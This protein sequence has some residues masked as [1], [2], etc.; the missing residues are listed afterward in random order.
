MRRSLILR[1]G[2]VALSF[3]LFTLILNRPQ[4]ILTPHLGS[5]FWYPTAGLGLALMLAVS[6]WYGILMWACCNL[7][8]PSVFHEPLS[9]LSVML[10]E[11]G[12]VLCYTTAAYVLRNVVKIDP[13]LR[14]RRDVMLYV[15]V[16]LTAAVVSTMI[17]VGRLTLD[18]T[19]SPSSFPVAAFNWFLSDAVGLLGICPFLLVIVLPKIRR[20]V[21]PAVSSDQSALFQPAF[22]HSLADLFEGSVQLATTMF[23]LWLMFAHVWNFLPR[24]YL[25]FL[26]LTWM[27]LRKGMRRVSMGT[28][29]LNVGV[30]VCLHLFHPTAEVLEK[31]AFFLVICSGTGLMIASEVSEREY[32]A[33]DLRTKTDF[34]NALIENCPLG[35]VV[36]NRDARVEMANAAFEKM[37][38]YGRREIEAKEIDP[39]LA[40]DDSHPSS[41]VVSKVFAGQTVSRSGQRRRKDGIILDVETY[42][43]PLTVN[44]TVQGAYK[45]FQDISSRVLAAETERKHAEG[46]RGVV[47]ELQRRTSEMALLNE[48]RDWLECCVSESEACAVVEYSAQKLFPESTSGTLFL[49]KAS[50]NLVEGAV[51]WGQT[52]I[53]EDRFHPDACWSVRRGQPHWSNDSSTGVRCAHLGDEPSPAIGLCV[54]LLAQGNM[55]GVLYLEFPPV[56]DPV[57]EGSSDNTR[58]AQ[59]RLAISVAGHVAQSLASLRLREALHDQS[60]K[61][62]LSGLF[63]RRFLEESME[64]ELHRSIRRKEPVSILFVDLDHFKRFND[65]FGHEAG[66]LVIRS[67]ADLFRGFFRSGDICC[68]YGGEE[69][70]IILPASSSRYAAVRANALREQTKRL[71]LEHNNRPLGMITLSVG[72]ASFPEHGSTVRELFAVADHSLYQSKA[73]GR[74]T[75][76]VGEAKV[77]EDRDPIL[78]SSEEAEQ[79]PAAAS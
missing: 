11:A 34:L 67:V 64:K 18:H 50:R 68:R 29:V 44:G 25:S 1:H 52:G 15:G 60:I 37:F 14:H 30:V 66:D 69:F 28:L 70:A 2:A 32:T 13:E 20:W 56:A 9:S 73:S 31:A 53:S 27:A 79:S 49:F 57:R 41:D 78:G 76:T 8:D 51:R 35:I 33:W 47:Q 43:V 3:F 36:L 19:F 74:D 77:P 38:L 63:N 48:M 6:P 17:G 72:V 71:A 55:L 7:T 54:P 23:C 16:S 10:G 75:V 5:T 4:V 65:T 45:I 22:S 12:M 59:R 24:F 39:L 40:P 62:P 26:P 61:D 42:A 21:S 46:L 58:D